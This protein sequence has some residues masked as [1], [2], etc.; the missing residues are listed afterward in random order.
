[1]TE[2][3]LFLLSIDIKEGIEYIVS[4]NVLEL[5]PPRIKNDLSNTVRDNLYSFV[6]SI[7]KA[8]PDW[9]KLK[10][11]DVVNKED[12]TELWYFARIPYE[13]KYMIDNSHHLIKLSATED[14][15]ILRLKYFL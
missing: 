9:L 15:N 4:K 5:Q 12:K 2:I 11:V 10:I 3:I 14:N 1:M 8:N 13:Y 7:I 6:Q